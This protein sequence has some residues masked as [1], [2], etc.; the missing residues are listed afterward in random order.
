MG[1][2]FRRFLVGDMEE[3]RRVHPATPSGVN[4]K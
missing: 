3:G 2:W 4:R 1:G